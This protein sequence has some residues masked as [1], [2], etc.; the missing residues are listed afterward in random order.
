MPFIADSMSDLWRRWHIT[1]TNWLRD[2][3]L[4]PISGFRGS[5]LRF[6]AAIMIT[7]A[8][9]GLWHGASWNFVVWGVYFGLCLVI[10]QHFKRWRENT[11]FLKSFFESKYFHALSVLLTFQAFCLGAVIFRIRDVGMDFQLVKKMLLLSHMRGTFQDHQYILA[12]SDFPVFVPVVLFI[13][14]ALLLSNIPISKLQ[15]SG[16]IAA[17][18][19]P[20]R[21]SYLVLLVFAMLIF[22][23]RVS[24]PFIYFQF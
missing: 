7:M 9:C 2:Y 4:I 14:A 24:T 3:L 20:I 22:I 21:A 6:S 15:Q 18:P 11:L 8:V 19:V 13:L 23:P 12:R 10:N 17:L 16:R 1:L 5:S